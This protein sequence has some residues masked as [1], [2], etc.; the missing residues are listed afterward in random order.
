MPRFKKHL[1]A[2]QACKKSFPGGI[3]ITVTMTI[4]DEQGIVW[5]FWMMVKVNFV[6]ADHN[7]MVRSDKR[8]ARMQHCSV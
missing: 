6:I 5:K 2:S 3:L 1:Y 4:A 8:H 7:T